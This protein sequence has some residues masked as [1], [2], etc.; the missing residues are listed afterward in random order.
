MTDKGSEPSAGTTPEVPPPA[1][2]SPS[3]PDDS[4]SQEFLSYEGARIPAFIVILWIVFLVFGIVY[5]LIYLP[6]SIREWFL[7]GSPDG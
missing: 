3:T 2:D 4:E 1:G 7:D 6:D 5:F